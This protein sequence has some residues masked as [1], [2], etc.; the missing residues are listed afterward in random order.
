MFYY[1][2]NK[3]VNATFISR[4]LNSSRSTISIN[5]NEL[6]KMELIRKIVY[7]RKEKRAIFYCITSF[8]RSIIKLILE[9]NSKMNSFK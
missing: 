2:E 1:N 5:L 6:L 9:I 3:E 7:N 4:N 8:G